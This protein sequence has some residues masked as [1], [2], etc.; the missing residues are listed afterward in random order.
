MDV[1]LVVAI[2]FTYRDL[3]VEIIQNNQQIALFVNLVGTIYST[4]DCLCLV[5]YSG[6]FVLTIATM[7][8]RWIQFQLNQFRVGRLSSCV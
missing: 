2:G 4:I 8:V 1:W 7:Q 3:I 5:Q 6:T